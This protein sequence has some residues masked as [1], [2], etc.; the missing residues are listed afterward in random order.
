[1]HAIEPP[2]AAAQGCAVIFGNLD[3]G[4][5]GYRTNVHSDM[6]TIIFSKGN[7]CASEVVSLP[8]I[9]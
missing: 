3:A 1:M 5:S 8:K 4:I 9:A 7:Q 6:E 2:Q